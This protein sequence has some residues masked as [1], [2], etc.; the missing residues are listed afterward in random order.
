[1]KIDHIALYCKDIE[2][3]KSFFVRFFHAE[4]GPMYHNTTTNFRSYFLSFE[5]SDARLELMT[6]PNVKPTEQYPYA[7]GFAHICMSVG[8]RE[9]V[10]TITEQIENSGFRVQ[11]KP[12]TTGDGYYESCIIGP[13]GILIEITI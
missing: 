7:A 11:S 1:M 9:Q 4:S 3:M 6:R 12:R 2:S 10:D 13:E 5:N 8:S